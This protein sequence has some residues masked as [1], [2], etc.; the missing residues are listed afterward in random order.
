MIIGVNE[1]GLDGLSH[2][3]RDAIARAEVLIGGPRHLALVGAGG[4][5]VA[6]P[7]P[8][9]VA[10]VLAH[11]GR[12]VVILASG[13]PFWFGAGGSIAPHLHPDEWR[14]IPAPSTFAFMASALGWGLENVS[15][16]GL[17]AAPFARLRPS[18]QNGARLF[19]LLR[20]GQAPADLAQYLCDLGFGGSELHVMERLGGP[21]QRI[22]KITAERFD[23]TDISAPVA[24]AILAQGL[25]LSH[26]LGLPDDAFVNDGQITKRPI[27]AM[28]LSALAPRRFEHLWDIGGGSGSVSVEWCLAGGRATTIEPKP[29]RVDNIRQN[30]ANFGVSHLMQVIHGAAP[31]ALGGLDAPDAVFVG[32]GGDAELFT[33]LIPRLRT[34]TRLVVNSVTLETEALLVALQAQHGGSLIKIDIAT[35]VPLGR[36]SAWQAARP[37]V[38]WSVTL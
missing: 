3:S 8:F 27:R 15:C 38:Q 23:L 19:C 24:V 12:R 7:V 17:H 35:A 14:A 2:D 32:G 1:N 29:Q 10:P 30:A 28:T 6:W 5:G 11:R 33:V 25:G 16:Q 22:R 31:D 13:D 26:A 36:M 20:D 9:D 18:L 4:R 37:V 21:H 34:C